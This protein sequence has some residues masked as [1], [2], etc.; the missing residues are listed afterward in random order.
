MEKYRYIDVDFSQ[1]DGEDILTRVIQ[2]K[3]WYGWVTI[4][5]IED[6]LTVV[7]NKTVK[8]LKLLQNED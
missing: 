6:E 8:I 3:K 5:T 1:E 2:V 4:Y 7:I